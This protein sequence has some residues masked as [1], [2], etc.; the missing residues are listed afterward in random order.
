MYIYCLIVLPF[1]VVD[2]SFHVLSFPFIVLVYCGRFREITE[3]Y[4]RLR[5]IVMGSDCLT[6]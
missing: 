2:G 1:I 3:D 4:R 6:V 5:E